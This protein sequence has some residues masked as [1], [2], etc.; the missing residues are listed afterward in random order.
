V[1]IVA[2]VD[3]HRQR[4]VDKANE[5]NAQFSTDNLAEALSYEEVTAVVIA[6]AH[7]HHAPQSMR[8]LEADKDV[9]V[10][11]PFATSLAEA[12]A[13]ISAADQAGRL[14]MV[15]ENARYE[16]AYQRMARLIAEDLIGEPFLC[17]ISRDHHMH[18]DLRRNRPWLLSDPTGGIMWSGGIHDIE[19][20]LMLFGEVP[21]EQVQAMPVM[22]TF[23]EM[24]AD[25]T[26]IGLF[27]FAGD[28]VA[29]LSESFS[30][31]APAGQRIR[32]EVFGALGSLATDGDA[33]VSHVGTDES[34]KDLKVP[35]ADTFRVEAQHFV[36]CINSGDQPVTAAARM[37]RGLAAIVAAYESMRTNAP[38][39]VASQA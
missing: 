26:S 6:V 32:V 9:L 15:A 13:M 23:P 10:E 35:F 30:T 1:R 31:Y 16:P 5:W 29:V 8:A 33:S 28:R 2:V 24:A 20:A 18:D 17:R 4:A 27:R 19:T 37:R 7:A 25:D 38:V 21:C 3:Q 36:D 39:A 22:K 14:C 12:D 34:R 11:K